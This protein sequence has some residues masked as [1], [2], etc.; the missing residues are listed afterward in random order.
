VITYS[1]VGTSATYNSGN[2]ITYGPALTVTYASG[3]KSGS[4]Y[5]GVTYNSINPVVSY[6]AAG[7]AF[8]PT[9]TG[10]SY[11][12]SG[13]AFAQ[14]GKSYAIDS[15][16]GYKAPPKTQ[17]YANLTPLNSTLSGKFGPAIATPEPSGV[18]LVLGGL[19]VLFVLRR[20][21]AL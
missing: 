15:N 13:N 5:G 14:Y 9:Y 21:F 1:S 8:M 7:S 17:L 11:S 4:S 18:L 10:V 2:T 16:Y 3:N 6:S 20:R 12:L 19:G